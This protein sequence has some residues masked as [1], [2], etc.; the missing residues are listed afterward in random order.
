MDKRNRK[1]FRPLSAAVVTLA[2]TSC[3]GSN[4]PNPRIPPPDSSIAYVDGYTPGC[5]SGFTDAGRVGYETSY[6]KDAVRY[7]TDSD[8]KAGWDKGHDACYL[9]EKLHPRVKG[10]NP[11]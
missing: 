7:R 5:V 6:Y 4:S 2:L 3:T 8:Y 1:A 10:D 11:T 9:E